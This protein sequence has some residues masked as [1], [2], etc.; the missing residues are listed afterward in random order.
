MG[1]SSFPSP[2]EGMLPLLV[3]NTVISVALVK[4]LL[5]SLL[6]LVGANGGGGGAEQD[7]DEEASRTRRGSITRYN[8]LCRN[9]CGGVRRRCRDDGGCS[10][11]GG[12]GGNMWP[13]M[14]CCVCLC[15]FEGDEEV[16]ELCC[17]H[18]FHKGCLEKWFH[19]Q[20]TT[21]P[22]CRSTV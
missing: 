7:F 3:K 10:G 9:R 6:Q 18:F 12:A 17:K 1:L 19:N 11:S 21:C 20:H 5:R 13:T 4:N 15:R 22:L 2:A 16:I 8:S 14:E